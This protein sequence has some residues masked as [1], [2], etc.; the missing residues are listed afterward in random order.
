M[1]EE[2]LQLGININSRWLQST[3]DGGSRP[4]ELCHVQALKTFKMLER[5]GSWHSLG[6]SACVLLSASFRSGP[7]WSSGGRKSF[8][9]REGLL[10]WVK[11][12]DMNGRKAQ[13]PN[14]GHSHSDKRAKY[15]ENWG[16][17]MIDGIPRVIWF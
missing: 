8:E 9:G 6:C 3:Q 2:L 14:C 16:D 10:T 13:K 15:L 11:L 12:K 17:W 5:S 7:R 1:F 4:G